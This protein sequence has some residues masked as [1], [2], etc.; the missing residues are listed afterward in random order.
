MLR[1]YFIIAW[2]AMSRQ[3]LY[4]GIKVGGFALGIAT[5]LIIALYIRHELRHDKW[6]A[7]EERVYR[8]YNEDRKEGTGG[9][10]T[11][12]PAP[13]ASIIREE[14]PEV[15]KAGRLIPFSG[16]YMAGSNLF[17]RDDQIE[18][19]Y[20]EGFA[21]A[22]Q[23]L[24]DIL[25]VP[26][27]SGD[28]HQALAKPRSL[29]IS[30]RIAKKY[31]PKEDPIGRVVVLNDQDS[32]PYTIGGV[33][34]DIKDRSHID[35]DFFISLKG[36]EFWEG[37]QTNWCCWNY[38]VYIKTQPGTD[39]KVLEKK[40]LSLRDNHYMKFLRE[41]ENQS[42]AETQKN[43]FVRL[44]S[45]EDVYLKSAEIHGSMKRGDIVYVKLLGGIAI[46]ILLIACVNFINLTTARSANRARE[47][48]LRK[49]VG[50]LRSYLIR[51]FLSE[52]LLYSLISFAFG[53][54][55]VWLVM[56]YFS[57]LAGSTLVIPW[58]EP[59]FFPILGVATL[60]VGIVAGLYPSIYLSSFKPI[61]VLKGNVSRGA[62]SG[63][64]RGALVV[65]Q[66]TTSIFLIIGTLVIHRQMNYILNTKIGFDKDQ[67]IMIEG[68]NTLDQ[69]KTFKEELKQ[70]PH[71]EHVAVSSYMPISGS[72]RDQN[73]FW[74]DGKSKEEQGIGAQKWY[75]D[76][77][78]MKTLGMRLVEGRT[79]DPDIKSDTSAMIINQAMAKEFGFEKPVGEFIQNWE[80][81]HIIGVVED[82]NFES[83]KGKIRP[84]AFVYG[85]WGA[86]ISVKVKT[87][88]MQ[89]TLAAIGAV[90]DR[91]MPNQPIRY[92]FLD[93]S[94]ARMYEDVQRMGRIFTCFAVLALIVACLGLFALSAFMVEQRGKEIS[95]R[96]VLGAS[97]NNIFTMVTQNFVIL[98]MIS[99]VLAVPLGYY[100]MQTWLQ[101]YEYR[102]PLTWDIFLIAGFAAIVIALLTVSYQSIK[103][104]IANPVDRLRSE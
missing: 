65:F 99:I 90:W 82:F 104:A 36:V 37:E 103:V 30:E 76:E 95:I 31:F 35:F 80:T 102:I 74:R 40:L 55:I 52:S 70:V 12:F 56:P 13:V 10:W 93:D 5:C 33:M 24:L 16:W 97:V 59:W 81:W 2:R 51:Q 67:V 88:D 15:E 27:V 49:V 45:V 22:D 58:T 21:Y 54:V 11:A 4:A 7:D 3:K 50:S 71:I 87:E 25:Q 60:V 84:L 85:D 53:L 8:V 79:F 63:R 47:V 29:V 61:A 94:Y 92:K 34:E 14:F 98:V 86:T 39:P 73:P 77:D 96:L 48:G 69:Q 75:V 64:M 101:N 42:L 19:T 78:Y 43:Y 72:K 1:S 41:T 83:M 62:K 20:E 57:M 66:F 28:V 91:F 9:K 68:T 89:Q 38:S 6:I 46:F 44:Q 18:N 26:M 17:R 23:E 32:L 100:A